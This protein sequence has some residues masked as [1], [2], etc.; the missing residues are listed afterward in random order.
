MLRVS[1]IPFVCLGSGI[2]LGIFIKDGR[3]VK[4]ADTISTVALIF[5]MLSIGLGIGLDKGIMGNLAKIGFHCG[6][7][8][9]SA[10]AFSVFF[11]FLCEKTVLPLKALDDEMRNH[12]LNLY[13]ADAEGES[14]ATEEGDSKKTDT[15]LVWIMPASLITGLI[16]G[17]LTRSWISP[18]F[19]DGT[20]IFFLIVLYVCVGISQGANREVFHYIRVL[21]FRVLWLSGAILAGSL[22]GGLVA[23]IILKLPFSISMISAAGMSFYSITGAFMTST[24]GLEPGTYGFIVN[25]MREFFTILLMP[26]LIKVSL[27]SPIAGGAAG[28]MD[29]MLAPVTKFVG[30]RLGLV[31]LITGTI[32]TFIVPFLLPLLAM[33]LG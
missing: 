3:F 19:V 28:D 11:T 25:I 20:F 5:L 16:L 9:I 31:T 12:H 10:I 18:S 27:G 24:Y 32:L 29:T 15:S 8:A 2:M 21:G 33:L 6:V 22:T 30:I 14:Q 26:L 4:T 17:V 23:G 13:S 7:I 1:I